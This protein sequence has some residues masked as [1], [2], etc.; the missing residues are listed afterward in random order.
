MS[1]LDL[2]SKEEDALAA[3]QGW[4]LNHVFDLSTNKWRVMVL[5]MPSAETAA[6]FVVNQA[7]NGHSLAT[8]ALR[9]VMHGPEGKK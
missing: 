2:L 1:N 8:K 6:H 9:L 7:R 5:G 3:S 4:S